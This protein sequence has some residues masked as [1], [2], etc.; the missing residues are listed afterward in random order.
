MNNCHVPENGKE[1]GW[2]VIYENPEGNMVHMIYVE[3]NNRCSTMNFS[4]TGKHT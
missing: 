4:S 3:I 2:D 1:S